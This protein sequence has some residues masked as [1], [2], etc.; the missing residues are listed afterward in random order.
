M[1]ELYADY[2][3]GVYA[4]SFGVSLEMK[5]SGH[6]SIRRH[7]RFSV[8]PLSQRVSLLTQYVHI[9]TKVLLGS[10]SSRPS[11]SNKRLSTSDG[12]ILRCG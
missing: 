1:T 5:R 7:R 8:M 11:R 3:G 4:F 12:P 2:D 9:I 10:R 6:F